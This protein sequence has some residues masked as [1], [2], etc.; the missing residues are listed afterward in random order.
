MSF[1][2]KVVNDVKGVSDKLPLRVPTL[3][4][5]G[6]NSRNSLDRSRTSIDQAPSSKP[7][8]QQ[9]SSAGVK[10]GQ[11]PP[12]GSSIRT[13]T[14]TETDAAGV[15]T[16][17]KTIIETRPDGT[18][19]TTVET[20]VNQPN[21]SSRTSTKTTISQSGTPVNI[22]STPGGSVHVKLNKDEMEIPPISPDRVAYV[23]G[24]DTFS[25][26]A[27]NVIHGFQDDALS[28]LG[29][30]LEARDPTYKGP[31]LQFKESDFTSIDAHAR[32]CPPQA[33]TSTKALAD[34]L[35]KPCQSDLQK[36]RAFFTWI[37]ANIQ[38]NANGYFTGQHGPQDVPSVLKSRMAVCAGYSAVFAE[39]CVV[40]GIEVKVVPGY[41]R[42][43]G[44]RPGDMT[45]DRTHEGKPTGHAWNAVLIQGE[46]RFM[47]TTW[48]TGIINN[49]RAFEALFNPHYFLT[50]PHRFIFTHFPR[51]EKDQFLSPALSEHDFTSLPYARQR[52]FI[53]EGTILLQPRGPHPAL[54]EVKR[55]DEWVDAVVAVPDEIVSVQGKFSVGDLEQKGGMRENVGVL[56]FPKWD[57]KLRR[58]VVKVR[59]LCPGAKEG[60]FDVYG[61]VEEE[62]EKQAQELKAKGFF[63]FTSHSLLV[64]FHVCNP[65]S[66]SHPF[67]K[68]VSPHKTDMF[69]VL[70]PL[71][72]QLPCHQ[73]V[74]FSVQETSYIRDPRKPKPHCHQNEPPIELCVYGPDK[75]VVNMVR[76][77]STG[78]HEVDIDVGIKGTWCV[79][80][81]NRKA[82]GGGFSVEF[83]AEY[84]C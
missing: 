80:K 38:Y 41:G 63:T 69:A 18:T 70:F 34:Y 28:K 45:I 11:N 60:E 56:T 15:N 51:E 16:V 13:T 39:L 73:R 74:K 32:S 43:Y 81:I 78:V 46:W 7:P 21:G 77:D 33:S 2:K 55:D 29:Q 62:L 31:P 67:R 82:G 10:A 30:T 35:I 54:V 1:L 23:P 84:Q 48:G 49:Q 40:A 68:L 26:L 79:G 24:K 57:E 75:N 19:I 72:Q 14:R 8:Q 27:E 50:P 42:G 66:S 64:K 36:V 76:D 6:Q 59:T 61:F 47:D 83:I 4:K 53:G 5:P 3:L 12:P 58:R 44:S 22:P 71:F 17:T 9:Q 20:K 37:A 52:F 65:T 25:P